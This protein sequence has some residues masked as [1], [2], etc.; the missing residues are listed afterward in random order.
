MEERNIDNSGIS[1]SEA[2]ARADK[3]VARANYSGRDRS[4]EQKGCSSDHLFRMVRSSRYGTAP[5]NL[6]LWLGV[7]LEA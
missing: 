3:G 6:K 7:L 4:S 5:A 1:N 2:S